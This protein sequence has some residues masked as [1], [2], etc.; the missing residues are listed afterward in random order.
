MSL[1][2]NI[3]I[4]DVFLRD[5]LQSLNKCLKIEE[6]IKIFE[7]ID[8]IPYEYIKE[9]E[10]GSLVNYKIVP[11]M[12]ESLELWNYIREK[13]KDKKDKKNKIYTLLIS[14]KKYL[15]KAILCGIESYA[16]L[17]SV[18]DTFSQKNM[19]MSSLETYLQTKEMIDILLLQNK[20][21]DIRIYFSCCFGCPFEGR[22]KQHMERLCQYIREIKEKYIGIFQ[23]DI[24][25]SDT[26]GEMKEED[27]DEIMEILRNIPNLDIK[28]VGFHLHIK[29]KKKWRYKK[30]C[31]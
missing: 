15:E 12:E 10:F 4:C 24:I 2:K 6:K 11:Q 3:Y 16:L 29:M 18:S 8:N 25:I 17:I 14:S 5:G 23:I 20:N 30:N 1:L 26:I 9:I 19:K 27:V 28:N 22:K 7:E 21:S 13:Y 31:R